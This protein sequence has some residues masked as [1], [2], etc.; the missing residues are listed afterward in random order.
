MHDIQKCF[1]KEILTDLILCW[2][3]RPLTTFYNSSIFIIL[4]F[5]FFL[6]I[7]KIIYGVLFTYRFT[8]SAL[9]YIRHYKAT[10]I[11]WFQL[12]LHIF[13]QAMNILTTNL[14]YKRP[15]VPFAIRFV[16][17][18]IKIDNWLLNKIWFTTYIIFLMLVFHWSCICHLH[19][20]ITSR[21]LY[22][23]WWCIF[24]RRSKL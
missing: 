2:R 10:F 21:L 1:C 13:N 9:I 17:F 16:I 11:E 6:C 19:I 23:N 7:V 4:S 14:R 15:L 18:L 22:F 5:C 8:I 3:S 24:R 20:L 12:F